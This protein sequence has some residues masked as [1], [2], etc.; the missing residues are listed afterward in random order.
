MK[1]EINLSQFP[2]DTR[3]LRHDKGDIKSLG[4]GG[5]RVTC[6]DLIYTV[7]NQVLTI[8]KI[9]RKYYHL[10]EGEIIQE[11]DEVEIS[12]KWNDP[13]KWVK[14]SERTIGTPAPDPRFISHRKYRR[15]INKN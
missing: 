9:E 15:L 4:H 2:F 5:F 11:G 7:R 1:L 8:E 6:S 3:S 10:K 12:S 14:A 13:P